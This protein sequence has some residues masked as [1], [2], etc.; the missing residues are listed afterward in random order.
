MTS[1]LLWLLSSSLL[2]GSS[3]F[4]F[5]VDDDVSSRLAVG[6]VLAH[7]VIVRLGVSRGARRH[8]QDGRLLGLGTIL[9]GST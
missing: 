5:P 4:L 7:W 9:R 3:Q 8:G 6:I 2:G 1:V